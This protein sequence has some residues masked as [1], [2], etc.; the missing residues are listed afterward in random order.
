MET[1]IRGSGLQFHLHVETEMNPCEGWKLLQ[2]NCHRNMEEDVETEMN[3]CEEG[4]TRFRSFVTRSEPGY[5]GKIGKLNRRETRQRHA[6][7]KVKGLLL[8]APGFRRDR[9]L[10]F[11]GP[12]AERVGARGG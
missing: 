1:F 11:S 8:A 5:A 6:S 12:V 9:D 7:L 3:P 10:L 2:T 4:K